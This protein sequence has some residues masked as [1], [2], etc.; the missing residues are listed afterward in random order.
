[1]LKPLNSHGMVNY[2]SDLVV[3]G[4]SSNGYPSFSSSFYQLSV[5]NGIFK[6]EN[7]K[8]EFKIPREAFVAMTIPDHLVDVQPRAKKHRRSN[9]RPASKPQKVSKRKK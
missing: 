3:M 6:W 5:E 8:P 4:G 9:K 1:M 2:G 7:M